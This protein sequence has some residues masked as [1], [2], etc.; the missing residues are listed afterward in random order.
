MIKGS[1]GKKIKPRKKAAEILLSKLGDWK[2]MDSD[3]S[4][5]LTDREISVV[6]RQIEK[7]HKKMVEYLMRSIK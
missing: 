4:V 5:G 6:N 1:D 3:M 2:P 7:I